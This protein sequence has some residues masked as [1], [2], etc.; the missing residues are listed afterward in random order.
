MSRCHLDFTTSIFFPPDVDCGQPPAVAFSKF[1]APNTTL[2]NTAVYTC[3][4]GYM[5]APSS[6]S[7]KKTCNETGA[8]IGQDIVCISKYDVFDKFLDL[9]EFPV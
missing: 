9:S 3:S 1:S 4:S 6:P 7:G 8:W 5:K 2:H